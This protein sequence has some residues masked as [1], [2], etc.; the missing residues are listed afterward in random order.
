MGLKRGKITVDFVLDNINVKLARLFT[1]FS[2]D[3]IA[4]A[5]HPLGE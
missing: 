5:F 4:H 3:N 2:V 1:I